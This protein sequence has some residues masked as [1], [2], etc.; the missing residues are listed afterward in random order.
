MR[1][2]TVTVA[3]ETESEV[4]GP[5]AITLPEGI[6][7]RDIAAAILADA[8]IDGS[9]ARVMLNEGHGAVYFVPGPDGPVRIPDELA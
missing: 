6:R 5:Y 9:G 4:Q 2:Y 7:F 1:L 8:E 3:L